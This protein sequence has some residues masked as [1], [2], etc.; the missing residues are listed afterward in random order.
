MLHTYRVIILAE[1]H[2]VVRRFGDGGECEEQEVKMDLKGLD[3][4]LRKTETVIIAE[5]EKLGKWR[6]IL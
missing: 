4:Q 1:K 5:A 6:K 2:F 3:P